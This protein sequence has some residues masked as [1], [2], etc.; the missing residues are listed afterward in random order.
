MKSRFWIIIFCKIYSFFFMKNQI[1]IK[2]H[3]LD[4]NRNL[5]CNF[6]FSKILYINE[7]EYCD[8]VVWGAVY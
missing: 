2:I 7:V 3:T 8:F 6:I 4:N 1:Y 5:F